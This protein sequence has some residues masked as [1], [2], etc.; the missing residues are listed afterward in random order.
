M[1]FDID[2]ESQKIRSVSSYCSQGGRALLIFS[3]KIRP[4]LNCQFERLRENC[5]RIT[6][7]DE[8][9]EN[10]TAEL[11]V[12][13]PPKHS[14]RLGDPSISRIHLVAPPPSRPSQFHTKLRE[15]QCRSVVLGVIRG[16][17]EGGPHGKWNPMSRRR[18]R[19]AR[20]RYP[21][22]GNWGHASQ[23]STHLTFTADFEPAGGVLENNAMCKQE[24][25][26]ANLIRVRPSLSS[27]LHHSKVLMTAHTIARKLAATVATPLI[28]IA[29][30]SSNSSILLGARVHTIEACC[31]F[32]RLLSS[33]TFP[34][35]SLGSFPQS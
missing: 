30:R 21:V 26:R 23:A 12:W 1:V 34:H 29:M 27:W 20:R 18:E 6:Q 8:L 11:F 25:R 35:S 16:C 31:T 3:P 2:D 17:G 28:K 9:L 19:G 33:Q 14:F 15:N 7:F 10:N 22:A 32:P 4:D 5:L 24:L 13:W